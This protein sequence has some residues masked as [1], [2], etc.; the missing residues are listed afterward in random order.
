MVTDNQRNMNAV[1]CHAVAVNVA[2][3][4]VVALITLG[5]CT[6]KARANDADRLRRGFGLAIMARK[7]VTAAYQKN[8]KWPDSNEEAHLPRPQKYATDSVADLTVSAGGLI[9][10]HFKAGETLQV[11]ITVALQDDEIQ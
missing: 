7:P 5:G 8:G 10:V 11:M 1:R 6:D 9:T 4:S 2:V 3:L